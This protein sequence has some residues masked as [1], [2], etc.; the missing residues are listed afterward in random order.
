[1]CDGDVLVPVALRVPETVLGDVAG[2][3]RRNHA[4]ERP[5]APGYLR[6]DAGV[7]SLRVLADEHDVRRGVE[8][9][10]SGISPCR[11]DVRKGVNDRAQGEH[12]VRGGLARRAE[13][14]RVRAG[15]HR[16]RLLGERVA[17]LL[18]DGVAGLAV[19]ELEIHR[20]GPEDIDGCGG[21]FPPDPVARDHRDLVCHGSSVGR[22][23]DGGFGPSYYFP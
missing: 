20:Q 6:L 13:Q 11:A 8:C 18:G 5:D 23:R 1:V 21:D 4:G 7:D 22:R 2:R 9:V 19:D 12:D 17:T 16:P 10:Q 3:C 14:R 15:S